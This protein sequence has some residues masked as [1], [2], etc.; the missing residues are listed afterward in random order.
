MLVASFVPADR[1]LII[2]S[3]RTYFNHLANIDGEINL[4]EFIIGL[5]GWTGFVV[6]STV[7]NLEELMLTPLR[8]GYVLPLDSGELEADLGRK[9]GFS[10]RPTCDSQ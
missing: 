2:L 4:D 10:G 6:I 3:K 7:R 9:S 8:Y 1:V 5:C